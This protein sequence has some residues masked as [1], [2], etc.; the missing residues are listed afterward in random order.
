MGLFVHSGATPNRGNL[1]SRY[2]L[3][4]NNFYYVRQAIGS[5]L[6]ILLIVILISITLQKLDFHGSLEQDCS[7][8][9]PE[10][11]LH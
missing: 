3:M 9:I 4:M 8:Y 10:V 7:P 6:L 11:R 5:I 1:F 2:Y